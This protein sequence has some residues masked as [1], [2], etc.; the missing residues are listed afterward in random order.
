MLDK[1]VPSI[2]IKLYPLTL[3]GALLFSS[4]SLVS[5]GLWWFQ[6]YP[7]GW[8]N[9]PES[10]V[11]ELMPPETVAVK[12]DPQVWSEPVLKGD[13]AE[14]A[15]TGSP[16]V[17]PQSVSVPGDPVAKTAILRMGNQTP[18]P[19]RLALLQRGGTGV[20]P[21]SRDGK[22]PHAKTTP[23]DTEKSSQDAEPVHWDFDPGEGGYQGVILS[24]P[25]GDL[26]LRVGDILIAFAQD[27]SRRYWGPYVVGETSLPFWNTR[28]SEWQLLL[29]P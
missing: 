6:I 2:T 5:W 26:H 11:P 27:G 21:Q 24:L 19:V 16:A 13:N 1:S 14:V 15:S 10:H 20:I 23:G 8:R 22:E 28:R 9:T 12:G 7:P 29:R 4:L 25:Q 3:A 17:L 18:H